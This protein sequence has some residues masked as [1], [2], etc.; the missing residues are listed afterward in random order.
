[1]ELPRQGWFAGMDGQVSIAL[2]DGSVAH[3]PIDATNEQVARL[4][5]RNGQENIESPPMPVSG[6]QFPTP[7]IRSNSDL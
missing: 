4:L 6:A 7:D 5:T 1:M 2:A 3:L